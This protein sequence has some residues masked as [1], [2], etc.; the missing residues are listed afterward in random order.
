MLAA[1]LNLGA[2]KGEEFERLWDLASNAGQFRRRELAHNQPLHTWK[3][4]PAVAPEAA[5]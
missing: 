2:L 3:E 5:A 4:Q 1:G